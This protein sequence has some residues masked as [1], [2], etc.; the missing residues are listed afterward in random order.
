MVEI[1]CTL[2]RN[3]IL[4]V[5]NASLWSLCHMLWKL[6][7]K[8]LAIECCWL[9]STMGECHSVT[10]SG[11][12]PVACALPWNRASLLAGIPGLCSKP[13]QVALFF[14]MLPPA[15]HTGCHSM[16]QHGNTKCGPCEWDALRVLQPIRVQYWKPERKHCMV[17][18]NG[19]KGASQMCQQLLIA[20]WF[21]YV[22]LCF[23]EYACFSSLLYFCTI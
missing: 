1:G 6:L 18:V 15:W 10:S 8:C 3:T 11:T 2:T 12:G 14:P 9:Y 21:P 19:Q 23:A 22:Q 7:S 17:S 20:L 5:S 4:H 16:L 13:C